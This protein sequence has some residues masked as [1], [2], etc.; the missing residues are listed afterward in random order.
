MLPGL[1]VERIWSQLLLRVAGRLQRWWCVRWPSEGRC[2]RLAGMVMSESG[3]L[4]V[5][6]P[7]ELLAVQLAGDSR[8]AVAR[9]VARMW[10]EA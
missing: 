8:V 7:V 4:P 5:R 2:V 1:L 3:Q 10:L 6:W 9:K